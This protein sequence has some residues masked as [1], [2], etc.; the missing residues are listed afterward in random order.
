MDDNGDDQEEA[1]DADVRDGPTTSS[2]TEVAPYGCETTRT[3]TVT[4]TSGMHRATSMTATTLPQARC[5]TA[6]DNNLNDDLTETGLAVHG[7]DELALE[8]SAFESD[9]LKPNR[10]PGANRPRG[11]SFVHATCRDV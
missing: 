8:R 9:S 3:V 4:C 1:C 6:T 5:I 11:S 7:G 2:V 10:N